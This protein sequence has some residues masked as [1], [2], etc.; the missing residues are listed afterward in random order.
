[1]TWNFSMQAIDHIINSCAKSHY[2]SNG[3]LTCP[4]VFRG[5]NG[6]SAGVAAQHSQCFA[7]W[8]AHCPGLKVVV[9]WDAKDNLG[10]LRSSIRD[11][12]PVIFLENEMMYNLEF[13]LTAEQMDPNWLLPIGKACIERSGKDVTLCAYSKMV[14]FSLEAADILARDHGIDAEVINLRSLRP[15]DRPTIVESVKRTNRL[16]TVEEGW[17]QHGVGAEIA[18]LVMESE[19]FDYLDAPVERVA[20]ADIPMPYSFSIEQQA[21]PRPEDIVKA[22]LKACYRNQK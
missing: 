13:E 22:T 14:G 15:L 6:V 7:A 12:D 5:I 10:L 17:P 21:I 20:G 19:A 2:M 4:I 3:D 18:A 16:V 9:P 1:M 11:P 8:Y